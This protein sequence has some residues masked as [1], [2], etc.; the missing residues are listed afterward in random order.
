MAEIRGRVPV[1]VPAL[2]ASG[3][4]RRSNIGR[5]L[6][7]AFRQFQGRVLALLAAEGFADVRAA[8]LH[9]TRNLD[10]GGTRATDLAARAGMTKQAMGEMVEQCIALGLVRREP[11]PAD[12]RARIL[13]FS[14]R[15]LRLLECLRL[16]V[17]TAQ[18]EMAAQLGEDRLQVVLDALAEYARP[19]PD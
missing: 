17:A 2:D 18:A 3:R 12:G 8:H 14:D 15:G 6:N 9:V 10:I 7:D 13:R 16:A 1:V 5:L 19:G 11:D 4:W